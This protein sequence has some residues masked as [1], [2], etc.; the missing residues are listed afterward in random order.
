MYTQAVRILADFHKRFAI[1]I[2]EANGTFPALLNACVVNLVCGQ[3]RIDS[4]TPRSRNQFIENNTSL[5]A[6]ACS[7]QCFQANTNVLP[8]GDI[9]HQLVSPV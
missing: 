7:M 6:T 8:F 5:L 4:C 3:P 1:Y 2:F 9:P